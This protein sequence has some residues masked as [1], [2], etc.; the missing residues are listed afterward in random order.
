[1]GSIGRP[2]V[3]RI[4]TAD[5]APADIATIQEIMTL[6]FGDDDEERFTDLD[7]AHSLGGVH[8]VA[9]LDGVIIA[10]AAVVERELQMAGAPLR[11]GYVEAVA[12]TPARQ[13]E[14]HGALVMR[15][16][17]AIIRERFELGA[18]GTGVLH[19]YERLGWVPWQG[20][21]YVR[22][23][24]GLER[25]SDEDGAILV[26]TTPSSPSLDFRAPLSCE[27]RPGDVW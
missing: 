24:G 1:M 23:P 21:T 5:L 7:W 18:L 14:G 27:W 16:V 10:H 6:A 25:T 26:L 20:P 8:V 13:G 3:R 15:E 17:N 22:T 9:D 19:F 11:T 4:L 12:T 2:R